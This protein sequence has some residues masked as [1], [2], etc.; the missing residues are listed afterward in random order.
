MFI[1]IE[2]TVFFACRLRLT[3][4]PYKLHFSNGIV[5]N[6]YVDFCAQLIII[7]ISSID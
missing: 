7:T 2:R 4:T 5:L 1:A 3:S 6:M